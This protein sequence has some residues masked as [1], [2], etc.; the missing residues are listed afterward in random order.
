MK[1]SLKVKAINFEFIN[2]GSIPSIS[3]NIAKI[4]SKFNNRMIYT[5]TTNEKK[6]LKIIIGFRTGFSA[7]LF[8]IYKN[9]CNKIG[10]THNLNMQLEINQNYLYP[11]LFFLKKHSLLLFSNLIDIICFEF[12]GLK[13]KYIVIY[14][15]LSYITGYRINVKIKIQE[16]KPNIISIT[17]IFFSGNWSEREIF[18]FFGIYFIWNKDLRRILLDYGFKGYPLK[19]DF[20]LTGFYELYYDDTIKKVTSEKIELTQEYRILQP[21]RLS[22]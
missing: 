7:L 9:L 5:T 18:D 13:Y 3:V 12:L 6:L 22:I 11:M 2:E 21:Q 16:T 19:K 1:Y 8:N 20:P 15:L 14:T 4:L 17:S 10:L